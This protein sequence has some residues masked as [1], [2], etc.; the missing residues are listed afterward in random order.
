MTTVSSDVIDISVHGNG[1]NRSFWNGILSTSPLALTAPSCAFLE[2]GVV[3]RQG[4]RPHQEDRFLFK[5]NDMHAF[6]GIF[7]GHGGFECAEHV[8]DSLHDHIMNHPEFSTNLPEA[9]HHG[10]SLTD[11]IWLQNC[12]QNS[13]NISGTTGV[14]GFIRDNVL[15]V[16]NV[17]DSRCI[18]SRK[19]HAVELSVD[20]KPWRPDEKARI[21][22]SGGWVDPKGMLLGYI[23]MSRSFGDIA[24]KSFRSLQFPGVS[25]HDDVFI[26]VPEIRQVTLSHEDEFIILASDGLWGRVTNEKA[27][28]IARDS[29]KRYQDPKRAAEDLIEEGYR[30]GSMDNTTVLVIIVNK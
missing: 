28:K 19:G 13:A 3:Q 6:F 26:C 22:R 25:L 7:D 30:E 27:V 21:E 16:G 15:T 20:Q 11:S 2:Y 18:L 10:V 8:R 23:S 17:G 14:F 1:S 9:I 12:I 29:L 24:M 5:R 4:P